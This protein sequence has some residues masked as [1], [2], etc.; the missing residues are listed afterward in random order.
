VK[1]RRGNLGDKCRS[2]KRRGGGNHQAAREEAGEDQKGQRLSHRVIK[3]KIE[4]D[5]KN[6]NPWAG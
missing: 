5:Q 6:S 3:E 2:E 4:K 1:R